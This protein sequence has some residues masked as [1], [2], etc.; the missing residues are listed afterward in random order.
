MRRTFLSNY[1][2]KSSGLLLLLD[3][4]KNHYKKENMSQVSSSKQ[5][6]DALFWIHLRET[7]LD[8]YGLLS[9]VLSFSTLIF[10]IGINLFIRHPGV[11]FWILI[12]SEQFH[13]F[14]SSPSGVFLKTGSYVFINT[15]NTE[16]YIKLSLRRN[17]SRYKIRH[18]P[19][20]GYSCK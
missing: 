19:E 14:L 8:L 6:R 2:N 1:K 13:G 20:L 3:V 10:S 18:W 16:F 7:W 15:W 12:L 11:L 4:W 9:I 5:G 17:K